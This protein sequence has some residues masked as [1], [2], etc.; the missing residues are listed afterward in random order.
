MVKYIV[1]LG[2]IIININK[3]EIGQNRPTCK[4]SINSHIS[5][6]S[7]KG[8]LSAIACSQKT[9]KTKNWNAVHTSCLWQDLVLVYPCNGSYKVISHIQHTYNILCS[10]FN[11]NTC[12]A[13]YKTKAYPVFILVVTYY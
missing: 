1:R 11:N 7:Q 9:N 13:K 3:Q 6:S 10:P 12:K 5:T 2:H 8:F 4:V